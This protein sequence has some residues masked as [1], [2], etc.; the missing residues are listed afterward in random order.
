MVVDLPAPIDEVTVLNPEMARRARFFLAGAPPSSTLRS[1]RAGA[2]MPILTLLIGAVVA[3][4]VPPDELG[5]RT[6]ARL[7]EAG[8]ELVPAGA[9]APVALV[10]EARGGWLFVEA[11]GARV[12]GERIEATPRA[13]AELEVVQRAP[14]VVGEAGLGDA[15]VDVERVHLLTAGLSPALVGRLGL[16]LLRGGR[17]VSTR[18]GRLALCAVEASAATVEI[19]A[20]LAPR[21]DDA[22]ATM[23]TRD[24]AWAA[25]LSAIVEAAS[26]TS[27]PVASVAEPPVGPMGAPS[28]DP[29]RSPER[30]PVGIARD[31][32]PAV[33]ELAL[34][35]SAGLWIRGDDV[36]PTLA[37][38]ARAGTDRL[39]GRLDVVL[40]PA[41]RSPVG[42]YDL[43]LAAGPRIAWS[44]GDRLELALSVRAGALLHTYDV[45]GSTAGTH[46][47]FSADAGAE[48]ALR[49]GAHLRVRAA[50]EP[51]FASREREHLL[52]EAILWARGP[53]RLGLTLGLDLL[54]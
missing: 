35:A 31:E 20:G 4:D 53:F 1:C 6:V 7:L 15:A 24:R 45:E 37:L 41:T 46:V 3:L 40:V 48:L 43:L 14:I 8:F 33:F 36:D 29:P 52:G 39:S 38:G 44:L 17:G 26:T 50:V 25:E 51:G 12:V 18:G 49:L 54:P 27:P 13:V 30:P 28:R 11:R 2:P 32:A 21:C 34:S 9:A 5:E 19:R 22:R 47:D 10:V 42:A 23:L 16:E